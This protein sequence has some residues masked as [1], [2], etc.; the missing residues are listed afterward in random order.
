M[1]FETLERC[2][3]YS[4]SLASRTLRYC[5]CLI[6]G[7]DWTGS[8]NWSVGHSERWKSFDECNASE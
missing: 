5:D 7:V 3:M 6:R 8:S 1:I 4:L 2:L